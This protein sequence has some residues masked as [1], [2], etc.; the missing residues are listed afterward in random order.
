MGFITLLGVAFSRHLNI[1]VRLTEGGEGE[2][3]G[4]L[5]NASQCFFKKV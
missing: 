5:P 2:G 1:C 4:Y 3:G